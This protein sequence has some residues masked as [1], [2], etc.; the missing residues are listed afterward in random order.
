MSPRPHLPPPGHQAP[1]TGSEPASGARRAPSAGGRR[2]K[3]DSGRGSGWG[4]GKVGEGKTRGRGPGGGA[5]REGERR[6]GLRPGTTCQRGAEGRG[7]PTA[8]TPLRPSARPRPPPR[9]ESRSG[10]RRPAHLAPSTPSAAAWPAAPGPRGGRRAR[11]RPAGG[12]AGRRADGRAGGPIFRRSRR[13][14]ARSPSG[15]FATLLAFLG[16][17]VT[18]ASAPPAPAP[19]GRPG[20]AGPGCRPAAG[21]CGARGL[22]RRA[23]RGAAVPRPPA[24]TG[25]GLSARGQ[26]GV[27]ARRWPGHR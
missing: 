2:G 10:P 5:A 9:P 14:P 22:S 7:G 17:H 4:W 19:A 24:R 27:H 23:L 12:D 25:S 18:A 26:S 6:R 16:R 15:T 1:R 11:G 3:P 13:G 21:P 20:G 8:R